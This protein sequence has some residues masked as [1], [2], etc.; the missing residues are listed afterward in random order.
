MRDPVRKNIRIQ[1]KQ[2]TK[3]KLIEKDFNEVY[4]NRPT[5]KKVK[6]KNIVHFC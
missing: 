6:F 5:R 2:K 4:R 1:P 3:T